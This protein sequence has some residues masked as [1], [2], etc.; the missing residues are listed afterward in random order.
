MNSKTTAKLDLPIVAQKIIL[1]LK[2]DLPSRLTYHGLPHTFEVIDESILL[3]ET[4]NLAPE[5]IELLKIA[6]AFHDAGFLFKNGQ[7]EYLAAKLAER[8]MKI[9]GNYNTSQI[10]EVMNCILSTKI[11]KDYQRISLSDLSKYLMDADLG[12]LGRADF[13]N[14]T[15]LLSKELDIDKTTLLERSVFLLE[16]HIWL[17]PA[18]NA[19]RETGR[20]ENLSK[21]KE[22][23]SEKN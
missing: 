12:N 6:A 22:L 11:S 18:G 4:D 20:K 15:E 5:K 19:L 2:E 3:A 23:L 8:E 21:L 10:E 17:T 1:R 14:R 9:D 7:N 16:N 13:F